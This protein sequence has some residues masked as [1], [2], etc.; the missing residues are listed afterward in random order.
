M[1]AVNFAQLL[2][3]Y[4]AG[5]EPI[6][7]GE[8][9]A[10]IFHAKLQSSRTSPPKHMIL[11]RLRVLAG[12]YANRVFVHN[13]VLTPDNPGAM[14]HWFRNFGILGLGHDYWNANPGLEQVAA[15]LMNRTAHVS[16]VTEGSRQNANFL[17]ASQV[18][19][20]AGAPH[21][22]APQPGY[23]MQPQMPTPQ[24]QQPGQPFQPQQP[25]QPVVGPPGMVPPQQPAA[26]P[27]PPPVPPQAPPVPAPAAPPG[28]P[29]PPTQPQAPAPAQP[30][31][32][33]QPPQPPQPQVPP[34]PAP[35]APPAPPPPQAPPGF[36]GQPQP[37][38]DQYQQPQQSQGFPAPPASPEQQ[39]QQ[40]QQQ[41]FPVPGTPPPQVPV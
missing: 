27:P 34:S 38:P 19:V 35:P 33:P 14:F 15:D 21:P 4:G 26:A 36:P 9:D 29:Q 20:G 24:F 22:Q 37:Q 3:D 1:T 6:P 13:F 11:A 5:T 18:P 16:L 7:D 10:V 31:G 8:Y 23:G 41:Q 40:Q 25:P 30:P 39:Q 17:A 32:Y 2:N 12:P 28:F